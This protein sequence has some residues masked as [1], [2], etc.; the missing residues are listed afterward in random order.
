MCS[1][2]GG[3]KSTGALKNRAEV[4]SDSDGDIGTTDIG[5][6][7]QRAQGLSSEELLLTAEPALQSP[8]VCLFW[9]VASCCILRLGLSS[10]VSTLAPGH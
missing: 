7:T 8:T 1:V 3:W 2:C 5:A 10:R 9:G 4:A 6:G